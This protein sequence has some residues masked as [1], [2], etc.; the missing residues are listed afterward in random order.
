MKYFLI[1]LLFFFAGCSDYS[2]YPESGFAAAI[3]TIDAL[4]TA[5]TASAPL[6]PYSLPIGIGLA[7]ISA[8][9][10][11][12]RRRERSARKYAE[13]KLNAQGEIG[14]TNGT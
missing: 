7:G 10:E 14:K 5:N 1:V 9:L 6:N 12:L 3:K 8:M 13:G 11:A 2:L 4:S